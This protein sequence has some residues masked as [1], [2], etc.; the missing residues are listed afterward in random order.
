MEDLKNKVVDIVF[1]AINGK[2]L[3]EDLKTE[4]KLEELGINSMTLISILFEMESEF[5]FE[6]A[7]AIEDFDPPETI[8]ELV[9]FVV[10]M[11]S[12]A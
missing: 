10:T 11:Q 12:P 9:D 2:V 8:G 4:M 1:N 5:G 3:K 6:I 7:D